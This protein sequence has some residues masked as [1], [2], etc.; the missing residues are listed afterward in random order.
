MINNKLCVV[1]NVHGLLI[2]LISQDPTSDITHFVV[3]EGLSRV[4]NLPKENVTILPSFT[5][6]SLSGFLYSIFYYY[7]YQWFLRFKFR[8]YQHFG[9]DC[10]YFSSI[11][12][13]KATIIEDGDR[14]Y[15]GERF[16]RSKIKN[17]LFPF[18]K[19]KKM[20]GL[21]SHVSKVILSKNVGENSMLYHKRISF[22]FEDGWKK[23]NTMERLAIYSLFGLNDLDR[24]ELVKLSGM[25]LILT[26]PLSEDNFM[27][28][29]EKV[30]LYKE[31]SL[32]YK[33]KNL[34]IKP[35]PRETTDYGSFGFVV[36][37]K[38]FPSQFFQ[39]LPVKFGTCLTLFSSGIDDIP[40]SHK[41]IVGT[42]C[43]QNLV[44]N[45]PH[46]N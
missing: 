29:I 24:K 18:T 15:F 14:T 42:S 40:S 6:S 32:K 8:G 45:F 27:S 16:P 3:G 4:V 5:S 25:D 21:D 46:L 22:T 33:L 26:Q 12:N 13:A 38:K 44:A 30:N 36:L 19:F 20:H 28:E 31:L 9:Q 41:I 34:I 17:I 2:Y 37:D 7:V 43:H 39:F 11:L 1:N 10:V 23:L 35:H